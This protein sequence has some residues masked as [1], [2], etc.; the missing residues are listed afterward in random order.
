[1]AVRLSGQ[2]HLIGAFIQA[3]ED[4]SSYPSLEP[5]QQSRQGPGQADRNSDPYSK[6]ERE[7][8]PWQREYDAALYAVWSP[9][10]EMIVEVS[11]HH[12]HAATLPGA[13]SCFNLTLVATATWILPE[14]FGSHRKYRP[15][16]LHRAV[17]C[18]S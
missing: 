18:L 12:K 1:M 8:E 15:G 5:T 2:K 7:A 11:V 9:S 3:I 16:W 14:G 4:A 6:A 17:G 13:F 10:I